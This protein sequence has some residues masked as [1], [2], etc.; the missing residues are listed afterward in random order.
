MPHR[1]GSPIA[2]AVITLVSSA[3]A[4]AAKPHELAGTWVVEKLRIG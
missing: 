3:V 4:F 1:L 2:L